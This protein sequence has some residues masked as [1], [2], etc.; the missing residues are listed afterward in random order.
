MRT[1]AVIF[2]LDETL[3][4]SSA[5]YAAA[6]KA[7]GLSSKNPRYSRARELV[8]RRLGSGHPSSHNRL[9][10]FKAMLEAAGKGSAKNILR[11]MDRYEAALERIVAREWKESGLATLL[12]DLSKRHRLGL[13]SNENTRT[14]LIKLRVID[15]TGR[16][17]SAVVLSEDLGVEKPDPKIFREIFRRLD[18]KPRECVMVGDDLDADIR[19]MRKWGAGVFHVRTI[20]DLRRL[21]EF[22]RERDR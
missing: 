12:L 22:I 5:V 3:I 4:P 20:S 11:L 6:L 10:Y 2:D 19:P 18:V 15:P 16:L 14:Q 21:K 8:K 13:L 9:L 7:V 1:K 17:F